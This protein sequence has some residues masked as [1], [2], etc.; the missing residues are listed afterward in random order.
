MP[1]AGDRIYPALLPAGT[2]DPTR[3]LQLLAK[4]LSFVDP[5]TGKERQ[6]ES[7]RSLSPTPPAQLP[8]PLG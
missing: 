7:I 5:I 6:F 1:I 3:P 2:D 4:S 8:M